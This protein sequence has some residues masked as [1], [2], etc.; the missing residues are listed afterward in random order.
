MLAIV[1][2]DVFL[3]DGS[4]RD[5]IAYGCHDA[6]AAEIEDAAHRANAHEFIV[7]LPDEYET[8]VGERGVKLSAASSSAWPLRGRFWRH[9]R[10]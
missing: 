5:N 9:R 1:Q 8:F 4:V 6:P 3:F 2:Q 10:S 7:K